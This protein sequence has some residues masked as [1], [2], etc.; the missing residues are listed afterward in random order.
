MNAVRRSEKRGGDT[1]VTL[2]EAIFHY[3]GTNN[4]PA[5]V[6]KAKITQTKPALLA[7]NFSRSPLAINLAWQ[8][9]QGHAKSASVQA[10]ARRIP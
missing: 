10:S 2:D 1:P 4:F 9:I 7:A 6:A 8:Y 3:E 5:S